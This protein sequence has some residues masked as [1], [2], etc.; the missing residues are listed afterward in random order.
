MPE[1]ATRTMGAV[2]PDT[3]GVLPDPP[4]LHRMRVERHARLQ[5]QLG[6]RGIDAVLLNAGG[7]VQYAAGPAVVAGDGGRAAHRRT[8]VLVV[9][10]D[11]LPHLFTPCPEGA[12]SGLDADHVHP[13]LYLES[14]QG[15]EAALETV[16]DLVGSVPA[17]LAAD[18]L[19]APMYQA[20]TRR[21]ATT[22]L[23]DAARVLGPARVVKTGDELACIR[24][25]QRLNETAMYDVQSTL[26]DGVRQTDLTGTFLRR[27]CDLGA[28]ANAIDPIWQ[29]MGSRRSDGPFTTNGEVAFPLVTTDRVL[30]HGDVVWV[31]SGVQVHGYNS[32]F[33]RTWIVGDAP[34]T[35]QQ[36]DQFHRWTAVVE[37]VLDQVRPG[38]TGADLTAAA[39][40]VV[41]G[42]SPWLSHFYLIHGLGTESAEAPL[43]GTDA[44][45]EAD[46][47]LVLEPGMVLVIEP[48]IWDEGH[49]G[50]RAEDIV[51]VTDDGW[52]A[53][54]DHPYHPF[55]R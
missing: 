23:V 4:D 10:G 12:P 42:D 55:D 53:L 5:T 32:D 44:G 50:Y 2:D 26:V 8:S 22:E 15:A 29:V 19:S 54:S 24:Q 6:R 20:V 46:A 51:A 52:A 25:A 43:I 1:A 48:V 45:P 30:H 11:H 16:M 49:G 9:A 34:P 35:A 31:D 3:A 28:D 27:V 47:R 14:P 7:A 33:G 39:R 38:A 18:D 36:T 41:G 17:R 40:E 13:S 37:A 21:W